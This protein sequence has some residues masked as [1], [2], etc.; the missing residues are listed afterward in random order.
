MCECLGG[1]EES[2]DQCQ[3]ID[4]CSPFMNPCDTKTSTCNNTYGAFAC[5]CLPGYERLVLVSS[6]LSFELTLT[7]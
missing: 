6:E 7:G 4:E 1:F 3:D 5:L 2:F